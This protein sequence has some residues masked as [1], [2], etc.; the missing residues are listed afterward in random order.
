ML[1]SI[2]NIEYYPVVF[3]LLMVSFGT[4]G[5]VKLQWWSIL[6]PDIVPISE[7]LF[8]IQSYI[9][10]TE[11][12]TEELCQH[13]YIYIYSLIVSMFCKWFPPPSLIVFVLLSSVSFYTMWMDIVFCS[14]FWCILPSIKLT[15][16]VKLM[17]KLGDALN[18][19]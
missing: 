11:G 12:T 16:V 9:W 1:V 3:P 2:L 15:L 10:R 17:Q 14:Q 8:E 18:K 5:F 6:E 19:L 4:W 7:A 13:I